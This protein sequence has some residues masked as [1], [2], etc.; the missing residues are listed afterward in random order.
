MKTA[1]RKIRRT[2]AERR[3][4]P[5]TLRGVSLREAVGS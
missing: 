2:F 4:P 5:F 1:A 3:W